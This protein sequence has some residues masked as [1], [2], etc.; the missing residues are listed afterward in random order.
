MKLI[1]F[2]FCV[3]CFLV[4]TNCQADFV[5]YDGL[6]YTNKPDLSG[7]NIKKIPILYEANLF[8]SKGEN[9][10]PT[11]KNLNNV[12]NII[13]DSSSDKVVIDI[14]RWP[15]KGQPSVVKKSLEKYKRALNDIRLKSPDHYFGYYG[16]PPVRDYWRAVSNPAS[17]IYKS[18]QKDND[19]LQDFADSVDIL[20][21]SLYTFYND[22]EGWKKYALAQI[23][24]SRR[25]A[26]G[27]PV[28]VFL[29]PQ[30]HNSNKILDKKYIA[31]DF[32]REQLELVR[33]NADGVILWGG[34]KEKWNPKSG[35]WSETLDFINDNNL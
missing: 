5:I 14:E 7:Y 21:P 29:W 31:R 11:N 32:W 18:W 28:I 24:E 10:Y 1:K 30:Y 26:K 16:T 20:Y 22:I 2:I 9:A 3:L 6:L 15:L 34:W 23:K 8:S 25:L 35:W 33:Q 19:S 17:T 12:V 4:V 27:K 13:N